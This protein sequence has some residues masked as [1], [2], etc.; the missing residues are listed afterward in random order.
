LQDFK[1]LVLF[2][3]LFP[4]GHGCTNNKA[5]P[6]DPQAAYLEASESYQDKNYQ[7]AL[8]KLR[9]F[10]SRFPYSNLATKAELEIADCHFKLEQFAEA[11]AVYEEFMKLHPKHPEVDFAKYRIAVSNWNIAPESPERDQEFTEKAVSEFKELIKNYPESKYIPE[12]KNLI[13]KGEKRLAD[14]LDFTGAFYC[15]QEIWHACAQRSMELVEKWSQF[16]PL[17]KKATERAAMSFSHMAEVKSADPN[18][19]KNYFYKSMTAEELRK[20]AKVLADAASKL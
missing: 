3:A 14:S 12:A 4:L 18:S 2:L 6:S 16:K 5:D 9:E 11:A 13:E 7:M 20:K 15:K 19:D 8:T 17:V 1:K 10:T